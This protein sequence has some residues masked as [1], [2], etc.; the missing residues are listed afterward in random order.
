VY[1][2]SAQDQTRQTMRNL[3]DNLEE[4]DMNFDQVV[5][6]TIYLDNLQDLPQFAAVYQ[7]YF[8]G[9]RPSQTAVQQLPPAE[10]KPDKDDHYPDLE[11]MS[12]IAVR[13]RSG[14]TMRPL[15]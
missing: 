10:R 8:K 9:P 6:T 7:K 15:P 2:A 5:S 3:L 1:S 4:A 11:Q 14:S 12:L 13:G